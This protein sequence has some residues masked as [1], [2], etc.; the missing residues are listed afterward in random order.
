MEALVD[1]HDLFLAS[2]GRGEISSG[3]IEC[4][5]DAKYGSFTRFVAQLDEMFACVVEATFRLL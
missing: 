2:C 3:F 1:L 4:S 5:K